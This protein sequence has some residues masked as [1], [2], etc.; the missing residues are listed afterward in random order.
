[1]SWKTRKIFY[2]IERVPWYLKILSATET[3][4]LQDAAAYYGGTESYQR[5]VDY[6]MIIFFVV[7]SFMLCCKIE[8]KDLEQKSY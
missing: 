1:M 3:I 5:K 4:E 6:G 2:Y 8:A 7:L